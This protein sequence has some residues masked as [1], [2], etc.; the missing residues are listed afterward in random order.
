MK[1]AKIRI[2]LLGGF[3]VL[4]DDGTPV[5]EAAFRT[6]KTTDLLRILALN[7]GRPVWRTTLVER[8]WPDVDQDRA[9]ASLRTAASQIRRSI[10]T[11][12]IH[13]QPGALV[14]RDAWVDVEQFLT[15]VHAVLEA[16]RAGRHHRA[17][18]LTLTSEASIGEICTRTTRAAPGPGHIASS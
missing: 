10:G 1:P 4:R 8:L 12:C 5:P 6:G 2:S 9:A 7:N 15:D 3:E 16:S 13:R 18:A 17:L 14:L 11:D